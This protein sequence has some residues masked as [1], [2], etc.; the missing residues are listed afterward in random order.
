MFGAVGVV[1]LLVALVT[2]VGL[3]ASEGGGCTL[4]IGV[5][6]GLVVM[7]GG[8]VVALDGDAGSD[9]PEACDAV[10]A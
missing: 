4:Y 6:C 8:L 10:D 7:R 2:L 5:G 3:V 9:A 1:V